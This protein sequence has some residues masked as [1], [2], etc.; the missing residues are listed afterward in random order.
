MA[1][2]CA[3][4]EVVSACPT[5]VPGSRE[6]GMLSEARTQAG[7]SIL[8]PCQLPN[9]QRLSNTTVIGEP[10]RQQAE[11]V[12]IG[13]FDLTIRQSQ[14]PPAVSPDPS[15]ASRITIDLFPN[16]RASLIERNDG[17]SSA[18]YHLFWDRDGIFYEVQA[19]GPSQERRTILLIATSLQ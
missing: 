17:S 1:A 4:S 18:L 7:F 5:P 6:E 8:Y 2:T 9:S 15:G 13:P 16:V 11:L 14:Y 10:G 12:F 19:A 3:G